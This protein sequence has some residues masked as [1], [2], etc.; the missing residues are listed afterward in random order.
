MACSKLLDGD[1]PE[2]TNFILNNLRNDF[3][4]LHSCILVN[5]F[6]CRITVPLLWENPFSFNFNNQN[7][8]FLDI[9]LSSFQDDDKKILQQIGINRINSLSLKS[10]S[11]NYPSYIKTVDTHKIEMIIRDWILKFTTLAEDTTPPLQE[12]DSTFTNNNNNSQPLPPSQAVTPQNVRPLTISPGLAIS[13]STLSESAQSLVHAALSAI[14][15]L[16]EPDSLKVKNSIQF[17]YTKLF[18]LFIENDAI[19]NTLHFNIENLDSAIFDDIYK[20]FLNHPHFISEI[21]NFAFG[22]IKNDSLNYVAY[23]QGSIDSIDDEICYKSLKERI[24][25]MGSSVKVESFDP[26]HIRNLSDYSWKT[27]YILLIEDWLHF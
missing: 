6:W 8:H 22:F 18:K 24:K 17:I 21:K 20:L 4:S 7:S 12:N 1:L 19:L 13:I 15:N 9:Y 11:F 2:I 27:D 3:K 16:N 10:L 5:R 14:F 23:E 25:R 26:Y